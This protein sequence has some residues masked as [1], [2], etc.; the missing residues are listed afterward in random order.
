MWHSKNQLGRTIENDPILPGIMTML[1]FDGSE[2]GWA[3]LSR[4]SDDMAKAKGTTFLTC[5]SDYSI[6]KEHV[7]QKGFLQALNDHLK[8]LH[9]PHHCNRLVLPGTDGMTKER[10]ACIECGRPMERYTMYKCCDE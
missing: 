10:V 7:K 9:L 3:I 1:T 6:W 2:G 8:E 5:L 4:G